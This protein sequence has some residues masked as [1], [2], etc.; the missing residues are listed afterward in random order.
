MA[1]RYNTLKLILIFVLA[2]SAL[3]GQEPKT[4][5]S[6]PDTAEW[7]ISSSDWGSTPQNA[8]QVSAS[9]KGGRMA[10]ILKETDGYCVWIDGQKGRKYV[11]IPK[12]G[13]AFN[14]T[15]E[16]MIYAAQVGSKLVLVENG[17]ESS[18]YDSLGIPVFS[19]DGKH[20]AA[21]AKTGSMQV[22]LYDGQESMKYEGLG[23]DIVF[24]DDS[25]HYAYFAKIRGK[26]SVVW[27]GKAQSLSFDEY[28]VKTL[29]ISSD[30]KQI[31]YVGKEGG[32]DYVVFNQQ[33]SQ[34]LHVGS[35]SLLLSKDGKHIVYTSLNGNEQKVC[36]DGKCGAGFE[37]IGN[38]SIMLSE[39]SSH[40]LYI[41]LKQSKWRLVRDG[42]EETPCD[43]IFEGTLKMS[44]NGNR[45]AYG[46]RSNQST[47]VIVNSAEATT[48]DG[49]LKSGQPK[50]NKTGNLLAYSIGRGNKQYMIING[51]ASRAYDG[52]GP[53]MFSDKG[54]HAAHIA[55]DGASTLF[56]LDGNESIAFVGGHDLVSFSPD[57]KY[58]A[59]A[60]KKSN[61]KWVVVIEGKELAECDRIIPE[62]IAFPGN[63]ICRFVAI[64]DHHFIQVICKRSSM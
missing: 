19:P 55:K 17:K 40:F 61:D 38:S 12:N 3:A 24:S 50:F 35:N 46:C 4:T 44:S 54:E 20:V 29:A 23:D 2:L 43:A 64:K 62:S 63:D 32:N 28:G 58:S 13:I 27:D 21:P 31:A 56:V 22:M 26:V 57:G 37:L 60:A 33:K 51:K 52:V 11:Q 41:A 49:I 16:R 39:D 25:E 45:W 6:R 42:N 36:M 9:P 5:G 59:Y 53:I 7:L 1:R 8:I 48:C 47:K 18:Q 14:P 15:G 34:P 10:L 30:G